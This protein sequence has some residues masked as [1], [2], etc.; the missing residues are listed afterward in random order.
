[1]LKVTDYRSPDFTQE[2]PL[3]DSLAIGVLPYALAAHLLAGEN[4]ELSAFFNSKYM[5]AFGELRDKT[6]ASFE[7]I[8]TPYGLF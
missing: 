1:M 4:D 7:R 2:I 6:P 3:D 8:E 5:T